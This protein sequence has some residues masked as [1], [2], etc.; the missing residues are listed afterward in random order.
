MTDSLAEAFPKE[1]MRVRELLIA[2]KEISVPGIFGSYYLENLLQRA[3]KAAAE[4][5]TVAMIRLLK[6]MQGC[7]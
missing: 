4:G 3:E 2:Y 7:Q 6:E 5:D 1:Q